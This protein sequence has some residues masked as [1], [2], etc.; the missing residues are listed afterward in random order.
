ME[1][2]PLIKETSLSSQQRP[3]DKATIDYVVD[4]KA[5]CQG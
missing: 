5:S 1:L 3:L 4:T 2:S